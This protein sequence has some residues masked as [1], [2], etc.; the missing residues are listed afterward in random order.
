MTMYGIRDG[1]CAHMNANRLCPMTQCTFMSL[2]AIQK[3]KRKCPWCGAHL[4][5]ASE[6]YSDDDAEYEAW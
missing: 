1:D 3:L 6:Y 5:L 2:Q 4:L